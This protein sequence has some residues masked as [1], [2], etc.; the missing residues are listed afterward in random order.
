MTFT[1]RESS[2]NFAA[3]SMRERRIPMFGLGMQELLVI[4]LILLLLFGS[5]KIP[6]MMTGIAKGIKSFKKAMETDEPAAPS[7]HETPAAE[8]P[9]EKAK[10]ESK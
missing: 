6:E 5:R 3:P 7:A 9:A 2:E 10:V 4:L 1:E 8:P